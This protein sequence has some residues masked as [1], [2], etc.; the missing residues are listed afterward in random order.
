MPDP[1]WESL[2]NLLIDH[3]LQLAE[4]ETLLIECFD[5]PDLTLPRLLVQKAAARGARALVETREIPAR[6]FPKAPSRIVPSRPQ[7]P[8][9]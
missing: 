1:R 9:T 6:E 3:S 5:L 2:A 4:D 8:P 7:V